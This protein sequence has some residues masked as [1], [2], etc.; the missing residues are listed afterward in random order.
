MG[1]LNISFCKLEDIV[2]AGPDQAIMKKSTGTDPHMLPVSG[3]NRDPEV[4]S[5]NL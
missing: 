3:K 2:S 1:F 5:T 4:S